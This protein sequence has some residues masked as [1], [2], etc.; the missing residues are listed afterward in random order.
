MDNN[1]INLSYNIILFLLASFLG[2]FSIIA[3]PYFMPDGIQI[4]P[5]VEKF[6]MIA[7]A[8]ANMAFLPSV[9]LLFL[10][11]IILGLLRPTLWIPL[12]LC[13]MSFLPITII[14]NDPSNNKFKFLEFIIYVLFTI[15][16]LIGA[17]TGFRIR[18]RKAEIRVWGVDN[19]KPRHN[20]ENA[21]NNMMDNKKKGLVSF[22]IGS[23]LGFIIWSISSAVTGE[24]EPWDAQG[25]ALYYYPLA[26]FLSGFLG[27]ILYPKNFKITV[28]GIY[29]G[30]VLFLFL[31]RLSPLALVGV[32]VVAFYSLIA[33]FGGSVARKVRA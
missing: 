10:S 9:F 3:P 26:L 4:I 14:M 11:G 24:I 15:P 17:Y 21:M 2:M 27:S 31:F 32:I 12:A 28:F 20:K 33:L 23:C 6:Q 19:N 16:S 18:R 8:K 5:D 22:I 1:K 13:T 7:T 29:T 25:T 30:Q